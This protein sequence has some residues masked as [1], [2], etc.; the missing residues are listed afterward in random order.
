MQ[1]LKLRDLL[2]FAAVSSPTCAPSG[3]GYTW[4][5]HQPDL[6]NNTYNHELYLSVGGSTLQ[7][8][9]ARRTLLA[10]RRD[11]PLHLQIR[12]GTGRDHHAVSYKDQAGGAR[13]SAALLWSDY[14]GT[15]GRHLFGTGNGQCD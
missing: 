1:P 7:L 2:D 9:D 13:T 5:E 6:E 11:V 3:D 10:G 4:V 12:D 15:S 14:R 8:S